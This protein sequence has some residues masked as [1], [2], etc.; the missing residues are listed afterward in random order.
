[1]ILS[2]CI[3]AQLQF[4][5]IIKSYWLQSTWRKSLEAAWRLATLASSITSD[6]LHDLRTHAWSWT[7]LWNEVL[8]TILHAVKMQKVTSQPPN[9][10]YK[11]ALVSR[12]AV[13]AFLYSA[14]RVPPC[15][16]QVS[17]SRILAAPESPPVSS[18]SCSRVT[19]S[20]FPFPHLTDHEDLRLLVEEPF[21]NCSAC[22]FTLTS[23]QQTIRHPFLPVEICRPC[24]GRLRATDFRVVCTLSINLFQL[25]ALP[26]HDWSHD[27]SFP[28]MVTF[29]YIPD[30]HECPACSIASQLPV[31][32]CNSYDCLAEG[33]GWYP[34][35]NMSMVR[36]SG[37]I[38]RVHKVSEVILSALRSPKFRGR[39][40][41][42]LSRHRGNVGLFHVQTGSADGRVGAPLSARSCG[43]AALRTSL[44]ICNGFCWLGSWIL[45]RVPDTG[46]D[47]AQLQ[48]S[49]WRNQALTSRYCVVT[50]STYLVPSRFA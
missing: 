19:M 22:G 33:S 13:F 42:H 20:R 40:D 37:Y 23:F 15:C 47:L 9:F 18:F 32:T 14:F 17:L 16:S 34:W 48:S 28:R 24:F 26:V 41:F 50:S 3:F 35:T 36:E 43:P 45:R 46:V 7:T 39:Q 27:F 6:S 21:Y 2:K 5:K 1:M 12:L 8:S 25:L 4:L 49:T 10:A 31:L 11:Q 30:F 38:S 44:Y 29:S